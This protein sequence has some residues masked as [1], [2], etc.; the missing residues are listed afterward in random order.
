M[1][2]HHEERLAAEAERLLGSDLSKLPKPSPAEEAKLLARLP[3]VDPD[4]PVMVVRSLRLPVE[5]EQR[6]KA[7]AEADGM[8]T[9]EW[10]RDAIQRVLTG[11]DEGLVSVADAIAAIQRL[12]HAA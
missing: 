2:N 1:M 6:V 4:N 9:S 10:V 8:T 5:L 7:A 3:V 12:P 11:R